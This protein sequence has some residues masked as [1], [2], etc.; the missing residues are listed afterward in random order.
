MNF[1]GKIYN[2]PIALW[3]PHAYPQEAPLVYVTPVE[4]MVVRA[5]QHVDHQGKIY[6]PYLMRWPDYWDVSRKTWQEAME[7]LGRYT[8]ELGRIEVQCTRF[9]GDFE[10]RFRQRASC[11]IKGAT[12]CPPTSTVDSDTSSRTST[13]P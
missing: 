13:S 1:R 12:K 9:P 3:I 10:R 8:D 2:F 11:H 7:L 4:R 5:G 6:H